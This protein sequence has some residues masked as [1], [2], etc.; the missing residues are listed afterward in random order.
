MTFNWK[1]AVSVGF[2]F[3]AIFLIWPTYNQFIP[4]FL[5]VGNPLWEAGSTIANPSLTETAGFGLSPTLAFFIMTWDNIINIFVQ[6]WAGAK[7]DRTQTRWGRR[8]PWLLVGVPIAALGF[9]LI[10]FAGALLALLLFIVI[11][12][13]GMALFRAPTAALL[14]DLFPP[15]Q[16]S[17][18]RG[19]MAMMAVGGGALALI[20]GSVLFERTGRPA[21]FIFCAI[22]MI[23]AAII[24][25]I[26]VREP[27]AGESEAAHSSGTVRQALRALWQ[28]EKRSGFWLVLTIGLS[29]MII[30]SLQV[31][32]SSF[33]VFVLGIP[34]GQAVRYGAIL[35][36]VLVL[37]AYA[38]GLIATRFGRQQTINAGL[39]GLLLTAVGC[40]FLVRTPASFA[41]IL[42]P[43]GFF[44]SLI[45]INDLPLLYDFGDDSQIG[46]YTG[47]YF[48][49]T[50]S[51]AVLGPTLAGF[52]I[53]IVGNHRAIFAF[54]ALCAIFAWYLLQKVQ[55]A[56]PQ[57]EAASEAF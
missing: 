44:F 9:I 29:F 26:I 14:G 34:L 23:T 48:V 46:A 24:M 38:S 3:V 22:L 42:V 52:T 20:V 33:A 37:S 13:T 15:Q 47:V 7:S 17:K 56:R 19:I 4:I 10:P 35:A 2:G 57:P 50:Q 39:I 31:G 54:A 12:N 53:E 28:T 43:L 21:P 49:A 40:Y 11:T 18:A 1:Q 41:L 6:S 27:P 51:A 16:R 36:L 45:V 32:L 5:Q 30:E 55:I 8:K 25:L